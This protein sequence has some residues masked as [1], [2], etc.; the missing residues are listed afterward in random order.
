MNF[1]GEEMSL[2]VETNFELRQERMAMACDHHVLIAIEAS[3]NG[4]PGVARGQRRQCGGG[5]GLEFLFRRNRRPFS[6]IAQSLCCWADRGHVR[7]PL[8]LRRDAG[9]RK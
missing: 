8:A 3:T 5:R 7:Q 2:P 6:G 4:P 1:G 9:W